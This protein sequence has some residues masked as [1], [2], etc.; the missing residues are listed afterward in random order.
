MAMI[1]P[2]PAI[3]RGTE[4]NVPTVPGFVSEIVVPWKSAGISF[5]GAGAR[6]DVVERRQILAE[7]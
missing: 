3:S 7:R 4:P 5:A 2:W 6:D 1:A